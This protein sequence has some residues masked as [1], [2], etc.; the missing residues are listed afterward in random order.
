M[1]VLVTF[2]YNISLKRWYDTGLFFREITLYK[3]LSKKNINFSFLTYGNDSEYKYA[4]FLED[5]Q[6]IPIS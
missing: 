5:I 3:E 1:Q 2:T 6:I 4:K